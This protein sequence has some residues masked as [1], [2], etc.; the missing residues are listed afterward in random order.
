MISEKHPAASPR[1]AQFCK[2]DELL[3]AEL[4]GDAYLEPESRP[5]TAGWR[6]IPRTG[7]HLPDPG[8]VDNWWVEFK[9]PALQDYR[10]V[11]AMAVA[12]LRETG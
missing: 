8:H 4:T 11:A 10:R 3:A 7:W 2:L 1:F 6:A 9:R 12:G 5:D